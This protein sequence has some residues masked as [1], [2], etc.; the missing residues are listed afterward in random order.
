[1]TA[2]CRLPFDHL[3][4][5][6]AGVIHACCVAFPQYTKLDE[7]QNLTNDRN[8]AIHGLKEA[9]RAPS[10]LSLR[11]K[12]LNNQWPKSCESCKR[13]EESNS[14]S[15]RTREGLSKNSISLNGIIR[16]L[17]IRLGNSCNLMCRM[18][19]PFSSI[20]L[21]AEWSDTQ[22]NL[23]KA[24]FNM[25]EAVKSSVPRQNHQWD[26]DAMFWNELFE[27][28]PQ[29]ENVH[30]AGGEPFLN[31]AHLGYLE[32]LISS[33][34]SHSTR[35]SYNTNLTLVPEWLRRL[36]KEFREL[37]ILVSLDGVGEMAEYIRYPIRWARFWS[38]LDQL[39]ALIGQFPSKI[40]VAF[41]TTL[42]VYTLAAVEELLEFL[43]THP[44]S[45]L[46]R[47]SFPNTLQNPAYFDLAELPYLKKQAALN[48]LER[49]GQKVSSIPSR[50]LLEAMIKQI[51]LSSRSNPE[52]TWQE[53]LNVTK[54]YDLQ[55]QQNINKLP[56]DLFQIL[57][58]TNI[59]GSN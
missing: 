2:L 55:R 4:I 44:F 47:E 37:R 50:E 13:Q 3:F 23:P 54:R 51:N 17:D 38:A 34:Q 49:V 7:F 10:L 11:H 32:K 58:A 45:N 1:L 57:R 27:F 59:L 48:H 41:N 31:R 20:G 5:N 12:M 42:Q 43:E 8:V 29:A 19:S 36:A 28:A 30:F 33:G 56:H 22:P 15:R 26:E 9:W 14:P 24:S 39:D 21:L 46:P 52:T 18:C 40:S 35:L 16:S 6:N 53:F 25:M